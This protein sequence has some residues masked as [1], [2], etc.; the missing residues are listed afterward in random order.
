MLAVAAARMAS[1]LNA[2]TAGRTDPVRAAAAVRGPDV[3]HHLTDPEAVAG[4]DP[5]Q[6]VDLV[7]ALPTVVALEREGWVLTLPQPGAPGLLRGPVELN[8]AGLEAG[9]A[10]VAVSA[11]LALI[12]YAVGPAVQWRVYRAHRP[13]LPPTP[14]E[15]ERALGQT[16]LA[17]E[18]TLSRSETLLPPGSRPATDL[19]LPP[20]LARRQAAAADRAARLLVAAEAALQQDGFPLSADQAAGR[21]AALRAVRAA[22]A[23]ALSAAVSQV[24]DDRVGWR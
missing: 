8:R 21:A 4:L 6:A 10:V 14:Y 13:A 22:A 16:V 9:A 18:R 11:G 7:G 1:Q 20:G 5:W 15:A 17:A 2:L 23:V 24:D 3:A 19:A 12:P